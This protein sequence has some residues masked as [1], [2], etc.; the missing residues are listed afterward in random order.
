[1][2]HESEHGAEALHY[3]AHDLGVASSVAQDKNVMCFAV[4]QFRDPP[5]VLECLFLVNDTEWVND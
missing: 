5:G 1:V 3:L 2:L 4:A